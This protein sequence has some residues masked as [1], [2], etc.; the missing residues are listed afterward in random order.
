MSAQ[1]I[2]GKKP[3]SDFGLIEMHT[4]HIWNVYSC[5]AL[6]LCEHLTYFGTENQNLILGSLN[7]TL[8]TLGMCNHVMHL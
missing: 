8:I 1:F 2:L 7:Y 6:D 4:H 3:D 5:N